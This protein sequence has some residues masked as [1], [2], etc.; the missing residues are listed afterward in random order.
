MTSILYTRGSTPLIASQ[1]DPRLHYCL[2]V[3]Q[4]LPP[5]APLVVIQHGTGRTAQKYRTAMREFAEERRVVILAPLFPAGLIDPDDVHNF[6]F[7]EYHGIRFD[8][9]LLAI[10]DE[11]AARY[12]VATERFYLHGFSG[13]GQFTHRFLFLHPSRLA[14]AS[15]GAP[16]RIT[17][18]DDSLP[19]WLGTKGFEDRFGQSIDL[20]AVRQVPVHMVVGSEDLDE[21]E[22]NNPGESNWM[23]GCERTGRTRVERLRTLRRNFE[24]RGI[25]V[26]FD[27]VDGVAH[28]GSAVLPAVQ[29]FFGSLI[30]R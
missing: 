25:D 5:Q 9:M 29:R 14:G 11:V 6:K 17:Q 4:E 19:W 22:I 7:I 27:V 28:S 21:F 3:P 12:P 18:L 30:G 10:I 26:T 13:G 8:H 2:Y 15:I 24:S 23:D 16:G 1:V 20:D